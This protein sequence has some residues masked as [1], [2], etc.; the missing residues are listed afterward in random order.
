MTSTIV[1][2]LTV[3][4]TDRNAW[5][6][7]TLRI[8]KEFGIEWAPGIAKVLAKIE[9]AMATNSATIDDVIYIGEAVNYELDRMKEPGLYFD[10]QIGIVMEGQ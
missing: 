5:I 7:D 3:K 6:T 8:A 1:L 9:Q 4:I 2:A 10:P